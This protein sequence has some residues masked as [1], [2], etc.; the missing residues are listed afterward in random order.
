MEDSLLKALDK[1]IQH[2]YGIAPQ[3]IGPEMS[4]A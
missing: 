1:A 4:A 2:K 3:S